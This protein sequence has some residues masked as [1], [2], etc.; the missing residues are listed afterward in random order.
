MC[1]ARA[2]LRR[3]RITILD[4]ATS[5]VDVRTDA[6][7]QKAVR[8]AFKGSTVLTIAHRLNTILDYDKVL[9]LDQ[10][11]L[12]EYDTPGALLADKTSAFYGLAAEWQ[13]KTGKEQAEAQS[14]S[15]AGGQ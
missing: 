15:K 1:I 13:R 2:M 10:G 4:E 3:T 9:V 11:R 12:V 6:L 14:E 5:S 7:I 8:A